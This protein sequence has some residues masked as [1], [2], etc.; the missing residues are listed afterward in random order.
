ML[1]IWKV[2]GV[3]TAVREQKPWS[4]RTVI[5]HPHVNI[6][7]AFNIHNLGIEFCASRILA[8]YYNRNE[9]QSRRDKEPDGDLQNES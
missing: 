4:S 5:M 3:N 2:E 7:A 8:L 1:K 9:F 6:A